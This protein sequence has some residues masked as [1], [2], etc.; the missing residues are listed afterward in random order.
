MVITGAKSR[1]LRG[2]G[3]GGRNGAEERLK[4]MSEKKRSLERREGWKEEKDGKERRMERRE[5]WKE[6][7]DGKKRRMERRGG[8]K[9][10]KDGK[11]RRMERRE[12]WNLYDKYRLCS[13][14]KKD[15]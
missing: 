12:G 2:W 9:E 6:E 1:S 7:K 3:G 11:K 14:D 8:W 5:G 10:E 13:E 4:K 15:G